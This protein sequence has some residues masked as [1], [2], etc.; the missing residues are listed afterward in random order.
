LRRFQRQDELCH[1][2]VGIRDYPSW[3]TDGGKNRVGRGRDELGFGWNHLDHHVAA[4][5]TDLQELSAVPLQ[6][7]KQTDEGAIPVGSQMKNHV[8]RTEFL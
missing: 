6:P 1:R 2:L 7:V 3:R 8:P 5:V 4:E